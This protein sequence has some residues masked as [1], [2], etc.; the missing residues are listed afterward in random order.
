MEF[1]IYI[2][3]LWQSL[4]NSK[5]E[6]KNLY[7]VTFKNRLENKQY[8]QDDFFFVSI[9]L[10]LKIEVKLIVKFKLIFLKK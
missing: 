7:F 2:L 8:S 3:K 5:I 9:A 6:I 1:G 4:L 10:F